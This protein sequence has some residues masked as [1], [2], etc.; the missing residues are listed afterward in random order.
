MRGSKIIFYMSFWFVLFVAIVYVI[1]VQFGRYEELDLQVQ[2]LSREIDVE[3]AY[4]QQ[5]EDEKYMSANDAYIEKLARELGFVMPD[6]TIF[7]NDSK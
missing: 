4:K 5:L 3:L 7:I 2:A 6:E 1:A